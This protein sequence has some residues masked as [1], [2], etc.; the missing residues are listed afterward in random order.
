MRVKKPNGHLN[1]CASTSAATLTPL[2][3][4]TPVRAPTRRLTRLLALNAKGTAATAS[5]ALDGK[6]LA[7]L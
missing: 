5:I 7:L 3:T 1:Q 6:L 4:R 2:T